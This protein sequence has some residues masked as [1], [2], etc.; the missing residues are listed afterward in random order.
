MRT[1]A[2]IQR[3]NNRQSKSKYVDVNVLAVWHAD[4]FS[5][6]AEPRAAAPAARGVSEQAG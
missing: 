4:S 1:H 5:E 6:V 2:G 3:S